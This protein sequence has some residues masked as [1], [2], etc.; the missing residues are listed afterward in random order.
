MTVFFSFV[1]DDF[2]FL[3]HYN[4]NKNNQDVIKV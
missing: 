2:A 4:E 3:Q 1:C